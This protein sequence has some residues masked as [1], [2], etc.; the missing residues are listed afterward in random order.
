MV[1]M[2]SQT[3]TKAILAAASQGPI[4]ARDLEILGAH[5]RYL[6]ELCDGGRLERI[7]R[8]LY[9]A[10]ALP[11]TEL[12][13]VAQVCR[14]LPNAVICLLTALQIH[15][16]T[17]EAPSAVWIM[18]DRK[19]RAPVSSSPRLEIVR[20]SGLAR[21]YGVEHRLAEGTTVRITTPAKTVADCFRYRKHVGLDTA[22][23]ALKDYFAA[24]RGGADALIAAAQADRI[25]AKM[26][27]Y[28][29]ATL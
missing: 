10:V 1:S 29:E 21:S 20:A 11:P 2:A 15:G 6:R 9:V 26:K 12:H 23:Q 17:T 16:L 8:G 3:I 5:R 7:G 18:I 27:P 28:I 14:R 4:R 19:A 13:S 22:L 25:Y 24:H